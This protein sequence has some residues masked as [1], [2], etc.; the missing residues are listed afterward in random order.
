MCA[1]MY[2]RTHIYLLLYGVTVLL[3][4]LVWQNK[5]MK[6]ILSFCNG[7]FAFVSHFILLPFFGRRPPPLQKNM[8]AIQLKTNQFKIIFL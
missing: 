5:T 3:D 1:C 7:H 2:V 4:V 8:M 6:H